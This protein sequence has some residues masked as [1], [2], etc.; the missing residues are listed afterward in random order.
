MIAV[1]IVYSIVSTVSSL[2]RQQWQ[3]EFENE[4]HCVILPR[5]YVAINKKE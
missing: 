1:Q 4:V 2:Q 5:P 3:R